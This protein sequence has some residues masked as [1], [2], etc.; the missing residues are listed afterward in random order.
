MVLPLRVWLDPRADDSVVPL[1]AHTIDISVAG[2]RLG[3]LRN[4]LCPGQTILLQRGQHRAPFRVVWNH[5]VAPHENQAG[6]EAMDMA[7]NVWGVELP[8]PATKAN[9]GWHTFATPTPIAVVPKPEAQPVLAR[10]ISVP[11]P[12]GKTAWA[13]GAL[14]L[15]VILGLALYWAIFRGTGK[16][17]IFPPAPSP[18]TA[19]DLARM[20][21]KPA[22]Q[23]L[24]EEVTT[25]SATP[26][27]RVHVAAA[28]SERMVYPVSPDARLSGK[29][30]L[31]ILIAVTGRI[32]QIQVLSGDTA[33]VRAAE[34]AI[35]VWSYKPLHVKGQPAEG[36]ADVVVNFRGSDAISV[37]FPGKAT[38]GR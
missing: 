21:P 32:K 24:L 36:E 2:G 12:H 28:P 37:E 26:V 4:Q 3:G 20:T 5:E 1:L 18:P 7:K 38:A 8:R 11:A 31:K 16:A 17:V 19:A 14:G 13:A 15:S 29:V 34:R 27:L 23:P 30:R 35:Q 9:T 10:K 33:L 25:W 22:E 6:V